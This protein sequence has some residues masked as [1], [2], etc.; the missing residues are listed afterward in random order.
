MAVASTNAYA[1]IFQYLVHLDG[2]EAEVRAAQAQLAKLTP[3]TQAVYQTLNLLPEGGLKSWLMANPIQFW[4]KIA[5]LFTGRKYTTGQY[6]LGERFVDQILGGDTDYHKVTDDIVAQAQTT[7]TILFGVRIT[8]G[9]DLDAL[10]YGYDYYYWRGEKGD[11]PQEATERAVFLAQNYYPVST[12]NHG[13]WDPRYFEIYPLV[14]PIPGLD[15]GTLYNGELPGGA[16]CVNGIIPVSANFI[17]KQYPGSDFDPTTGN[18]TTPDGT[19]IHPGDLQN[20]NQTWFE[21]ILA[22]A[23]ANPIA[24]AV[25]VAAAGYAAYEYEYD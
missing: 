13:Q 3:E 24:A 14:A 21:K 19:V 10:T 20:A 18:T 22:Y 5:Q 1:G 17:I 8:T 4:K 23:K 6:K 25:V 15:Q 16:I 2:T 11:I 9:E 12:Y 7:F